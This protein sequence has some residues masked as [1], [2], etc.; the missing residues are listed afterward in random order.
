ME[1]QLAKELLVESYSLSANRVLSA[2]AG[3]L[4][5]SNSREPTSPPSANGEVVGLC[6]QGGRHTYF[7]VSDTALKATAENILRL[8][9]SSSNY[10]E[11]AIE[12]VAAACQDLR[13]QTIFDDQ[14]GCVNDRLPAIVPLL[15]PEEIWYNGRQ[16]PL[17]VWRLISFEIDL[18]SSSI[19]SHT[20]VDDIAFGSLSQTGLAFRGLI[21]QIENRLIQFNVESKNLGTS[22]PIR[23]SSLPQMIPVSLARLFFEAGCLLTPLRES[24]LAVWYTALRYLHWIPKPPRQSG[25]TSLSVLDEFKLDSIDARYRGIF[26]EEIAVGLMAIVL[27]DVFGAKPIVNTVEYF[28]ASNLKFK[29]GP[30][31]DFIAKARHSVSGAEW[32][33]IAES[34]GSLGNSVDRSREK[35]A[36][37][38]V[39]NTKLRLGG[40]S[41]KL[42]LAFCSSIF[43]SGQNREAS[44]IVIDP[45]NEPS[46]EDAVLDNVEAWRIAFSKAFRFVGLDR[47]NETAGLDV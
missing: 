40:T 14:S 23:F 42:P 19:S 33:I 10:V 20:S 39:S 32:T 24:D 13:R 25:P 47:W 37:D 44:C 41:K 22:F 8:P 6:G 36:K 1:D 34:K 9:K 15:P 29:R 4:P 26:S 17:D 12:E 7:R 38:Q 11:R 30:I 3:S 28:A 43:F 45:P 46:E 5:I 21:S 2:L 16:L 31:A 18:V 27:A 35:H